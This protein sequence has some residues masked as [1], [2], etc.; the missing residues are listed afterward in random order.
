MERVPTEATWL[1][2]SMCGTVRKK[3]EMA[4]DTMMRIMMMMMTVATCDNGDE[5]G[6]D[7]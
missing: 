4:T 7:K 5:D 3:E 1:E 6:N 2:S